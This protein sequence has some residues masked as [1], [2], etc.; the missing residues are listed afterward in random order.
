MQRE[1]AA[2][3]EA[4]VRVVPDDRGVDAPRSPSGEGT[5]AVKPRPVSKAPTDDPG[6][7]TPPA[8]AAVAEKLLAALVV[9]LFDAPN[10]SGDG[11]DLWDDVAEAL[12]DELYERIVRWMDANVMHAGSSPA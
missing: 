9:A 10:L 8:G 1:R 6:A 2:A 11:S 7:A 3:K 4:T 12:P 5:E